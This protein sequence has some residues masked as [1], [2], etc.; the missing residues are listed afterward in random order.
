P[1]VWGIDFMRTY[2]RDER[3]QFRM[4]AADRNLACYLCEFQKFSGFAGIQAGKSFE[5]APTVTASSTRGRPNYGE[6]FDSADNDVEPGLDLSWGITPNV[7]VNATLNP[8]FS[9]VE[10]DAAQLDVNNQFALFYDERRP[11]FLEGQ[12][13][14]DDSFDVV[15]TRNI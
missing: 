3:H 2:P 7:I 15:Y 13:L 6:P 12:D 11:F 10:A 4:Y 5:I 14:F 8:D 9:Q 1:Q